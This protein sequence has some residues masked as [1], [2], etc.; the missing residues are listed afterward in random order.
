M[1][2]Y[3]ANCLEG[4]IR[5]RDTRRILTGRDLSSQVRF[6]R[7][8]VAPEAGIGEGIREGR[9][10]ICH[11]NVWSAIYDEDWSNNDAAVICHQLELSRY[12]MLLIKSLLNVQKLHILGLQVQILVSH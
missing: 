12:G 6:R 5:L 1:I 10:E 8:D 4:A 7:G 3:S 2:D 9:V 11:H